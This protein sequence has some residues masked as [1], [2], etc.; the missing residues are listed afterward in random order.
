MFLPSRL[1]RQR[2]P[3]SLHGAS[4]NTQGSKPKRIPYPRVRRIHAQQRVSTPTPSIST[5]VVRPPRLKQNIGWAGPLD[6]RYSTNLLRVQKRMQ[7]PP[8]LSPR[9][10]PHQERLQ[11]TFDPRER[12]H[13]E[14]TL[15]TRVAT[16]RYITRTA[17]A[18]QF[19]PV[20]FLVRPLAPR[21]SI[22]HRHTARGRENQPAHRW[23]RKNP[24]NT[25]IFLVLLQ[26]KKC[27]ARTR[28]S[29]GPPLFSEAQQA[30]YARP[31]GA[32]RRPVLHVVL[33]LSTYTCCRDLACVPAGSTHKRSWDTARELCFRGRFALVARVAAAAATFQGF[34]QLVD[35]PLAP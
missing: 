12:K 17:Y 23:P 20:P 8:A 6:D 2:T 7:A 9:G 25:S 34:L 11:H 26:N 22:P 5:A 35:V 14:P 31:S 4:D 30:E 28:L 16:P 3:D 10:S 32:P 18:I 29:A 21:A 13:L 24:T 33:R 1:L 27:S 19:P 15:C